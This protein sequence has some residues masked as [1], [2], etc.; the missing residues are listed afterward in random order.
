MRLLVHVNLPQN[1][2]SLL[3]AEQERILYVLMQMSVSQSESDSDDGFI[4]CVRLVNFLRHAY[5]VSKSPA[6]CLAALEK[7]KDCLSDDTLLKPHL[8]DD[9]LLYNLHNY[10][11]QQRTKNDITATACATSDGL[12]L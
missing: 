11:M 8:Q 1:M 6:E 3:V 10:L 9:Q 12:G 2:D 5:A 7:G 4:G